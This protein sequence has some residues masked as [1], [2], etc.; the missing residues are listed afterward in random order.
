MKRI[1]NILVV[2]G[3]KDGGKA[4]VARA[5][6]LATRNGARVTV[7]DVV[8]LP[9]P[10]PDLPA[11]L[12]SHEALLSRKTANL[13]DL[14]ETLRELDIEVRCEL[15]RGSP[16]EEIVEHVV[17]E[18]HDL[19]VKTADEPVRIH[20]RMFGTTGHR[21]MRKCPCPVWI[22]KAGSEDRFHR[23]LAAVDPKPS[24][25]VRDA[26]NL[27]IMELA[28]SLAKDDRSQLHVVHV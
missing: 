25:K 13:D 20:R 7:V 8:T 10:D 14:A 2:A 19:L 15:L 24:D 6:D 18:H 22:I 17:R 23:I 5:A 16:A 4:A 26:L 21:L 27:T 9:A 12:E 1:T 28:T 3:G 11:E